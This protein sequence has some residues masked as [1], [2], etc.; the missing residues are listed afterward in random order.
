MLRSSDSLDLNPSEYH[1]KKPTRPLSG[2]LHCPNLILKH[3][4]KYFCRRLLYFRCTMCYFL[5]YYNKYCTRI[6]LTMHLPSSGCN[7]VALARWI[8]QQGQPTNSTD[9]TCFF[10]LDSMHAVRPLSWCTST[11]SVLVLVCLDL[12]GAMGRK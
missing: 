4:A 1:L 5:W 11:F 2:A 12:I 9:W 8:V 10:P 6:G 3:K 7:P